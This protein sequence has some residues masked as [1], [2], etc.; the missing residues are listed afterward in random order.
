VSADDSES[1]SA[2]STASKRAALL[3]AERLRREWPVPAGVLCGTVFALGWQQTAEGQIICSGIGLTLIIIFVAISA[4]T[5]SR[6]DGA[7]RIRQRMGVS[8]AI[9]VVVFGFV[10]PVSVAMLV[11]LIITGGSQY[12]Q[13]QQAAKREEGEDSQDE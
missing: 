2:P 9:A 1:R 10:F 3:Y 7:T 11:S 12:F 4:L 8:A 6:T 13:L 5:T